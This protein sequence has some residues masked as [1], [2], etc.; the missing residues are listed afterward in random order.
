M[1]ILL[2]TESLMVSTAQAPVSVQPTF[3]F[4][5]ADASAPSALGSSKGALTGTSPLSVVS[6]PAPGLQ[7]VVRSGYVYN[8]DSA[9]AQIIVSHFFGSASYELAKVSIDPG[10]TLV[11]GDDGFTA[12]P[13]G[14]G[15]PSSARAVVPFSY[16]DASPQSIYTAPQALT[17]ILAR[18]VIDTPFN[19]TGASL[20]LGTAGAPDVLM[21]ASGNDPTTPACYDAAPNAQ[22]ASGTPI[23]L[24]IAPGAGATQGAGRVIFDSI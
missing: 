8:G 11:F 22:I 12:E 20:Q 17:S 14:T 21:A 3:S 6:G 1:I 9:A 19:G 7:R 2:P 13:A 23:Q 15:A 24:S 5:Y 10:A 4:A 16:G 18:V